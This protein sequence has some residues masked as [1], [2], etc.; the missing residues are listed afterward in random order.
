MPGRNKIDFAGIGAMK[1]ATTWIYECLSEHPQVFLPPKDQFDSALFLQD[2]SR[3]DDYFKKYFLKAE[4]NQLK[5]NF[6]VYYLYEKG[7]LERM[8]KHNPEIKIIVC[9]RDPIGRAYSHYS[10]LK[11]AQNKNWESFEQALDEEKKILDFGLYYKHLNN[12]FENLPR[13]NILVLLYDDIKKDRESF[14]R[15]IYEFLEIDDNIIPESLALKVNLSNFKETRLGSFLHNR[16]FAF[17]LKRTNWAWRLKR[18][19]FIKKWFLRFAEHY[20]RED[21][22]KM[23]IKTLKKLQDF[24]KEDI[25]RLEGLINIGL[26][27]WKKFQ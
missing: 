6:N 18:S 8:K 3:A 27:Q 9:L 23:S 2:L 17:L 12:F 15:Q 1:A 11:S 13:K 10:Y 26:N 20:I 4:E 21:N 19:V 24:Y 25:L 14:I 22:K 7:V 16:L 5:G